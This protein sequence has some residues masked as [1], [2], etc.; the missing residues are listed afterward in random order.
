[1]IKR[2]SKGIIVEPSPKYFKE[3]E[4]NYKDLPSIHLVRKAIYKSNSLVKLYEVN[5]K[6]LEK[7]P[8]WGKG[9]GQ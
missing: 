3:L 9:V 5:S 6:G 1:M 4:L 8:S 7:I 2:E